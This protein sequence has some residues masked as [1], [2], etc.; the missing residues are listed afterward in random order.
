MK[1]ILSQRL[2]PSATLVVC[3]I[4]SA[5]VANSSAQTPSVWNNALGGDISLQANWTGPVVSATQSGVFNLNNTYTVGVLND[6]TVLDLGVN[7]GDVSISVSPGRALHFNGVFSK[8]RPVRLGL[9]PAPERSIRC[10]FP[11][12]EL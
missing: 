2:L 1:A 11:T 4:S 10:G 9:S 8:W 6:F 12:L 3:V 7:A 5:V